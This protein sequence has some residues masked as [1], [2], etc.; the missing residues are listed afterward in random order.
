MYLALQKELPIGSPMSVA[1]WLR[2]QYEAEGAGINLLCPAQYQTFDVF[3]RAY[4]QFKKDVVGK[5]ANA[6]KALPLYD[7]VLK[8]L[9]ANSIPDQALHIMISAILAEVVITDL[10]FQRKEQTIEGTSQKETI[11]KAKLGLAINF[12]APLVLLP[13][14]AVRKIV[15]LIMYASNGDL[16]F[17]VRDTTTLPKP[18]PD[19]IPAHGW[20][21]FG[22]HVPAPDDE[23]ILNDVHWKF[24]AGDKI[25]QIEK[26]TGI[27]DGKDKALSLL[28]KSLNE[29]T[30]DTISQC[31][32]SLDKTKLK[33]TAQA[34]GAKRNEFKLAAKWTGVD[35]LKARSGPT[36][37]GGVGEL[38]ESQALPAPA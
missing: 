36:L 35:L 23:I 26:T 31:K 30:D 13:S 37:E 8:H 2:E 21:D 14:L 18:E 33:I 11:T 9:K 16:T 4:E 28:V 6:I 27:A 32:Y 25:D 7:N 15:L 1:Y 29:S 3:Q 24:V 38:K 22:D 10:I 12:P 34:G 17:P 5:T 19:S 20:I